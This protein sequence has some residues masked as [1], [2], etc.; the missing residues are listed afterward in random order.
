MEKL[1]SG[2]RINKSADDAAGLGVSENLRAQIRS[3]GQAKR[4]ASD[5]VSMIQVAEGSYSEITSILIRLRELAI[6]AASDTISN[7]ER[8][9]T[10][11][12][13]TQLVEEIDRIANSTEFNGRRLL[14]GPEETDSS[15]ELQIHVGIGDAS[16][17]NVDDI[18]INVE[19][20]KIDTEEVMPLG[21][22]SEIGPESLE[23]LDAFSRETASEKISQ[24]DRHLKLVANNRAYLGSKQNRLQST[25][26]N[27]GVHM[28]NLASAKSQIKDVDFA[29]E[30]AQMTQYQILQ[31]S[32]VSITSQANRWPELVMTLLR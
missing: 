2:Y 8:S 7:K 22:E 3:F 14:K 13:Y 20:I 29:H 26:R 6:Q 27:I 30:T 24:I 1:S 15:D 28:E 23:D 31:N 18:R 10:N 25:I 32:G 9:F 5:G 21:K 11:R 4:N 16:I 19:T 12:E 17:E